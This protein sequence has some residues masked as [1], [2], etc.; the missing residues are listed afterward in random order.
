[1]PAASFD[2]SWKQ[3]VSSYNPYAFRPKDFPL[4]M[5]LLRNGCA[6]H[7]DLRNSTRPQFRR[8]AQHLSGTFH[9]KSVIQ[10]ISGQHN[11]TL[12]LLGHMG[13]KDFDLRVEHEDV[14]LSILASEVLLGAERLYLRIGIWLGDDDD[15]IPARKIS[16]IQERCHEY[17]RQA[18]GCHV[19][20]L[21]RAP[22]AMLSCD[23][24]IEASGYS[25]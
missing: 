17:L 10:D 22:F 5:S 20:F 19:M 18:A 25:R 16:K 7:C 6:L 15:P 3:W 23:D 12:Q 21:I 11:G 14:V 13:V 1:M 8:I 24:I 2:S 4:I 9:A